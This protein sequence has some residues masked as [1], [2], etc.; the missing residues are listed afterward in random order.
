LDTSNN[1]FVTGNA[2]TIKYDTEGNQVW[3][4]P[5]AGTSIAV[6]GAGSAYVVGFGTN[7]NMEKLTANG[8]TIW[9]TS[10][11]YI[12]FPRDPPPYVEPGPLSSQLVLV[13]SQTNIYVAGIEQA[14]PSFNTTLVVIKYSANGNVLWSALSP[15]YYEG[16]F[17]LAG[18]T[19]DRSNN[20]YFVGNG[21][22]GEQGFQAFKYSNSGALEWA[23]VGLYIFL[24]S[25]GLIESVVV[26][27]SN[28][29]FVAGDVYSN[30]YFNGTVNINSSGDGNWTNLYPL[31]TALPP[32]FNP[33]LPPNFTP[34]NVGPFIAVDQ[35]NN[36]YVT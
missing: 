4:A 24:E 12:G 9:Q 36:V 20:I 23:Q 30:G 1:V 22:G 33:K 15:N 5:Y 11:G 18:A 31:P 27:N 14:L 19:L 28:N 32:N 34:E 26:D 8:S 35:A 29:V 10:S 7:F 6:D 21:G 3:S 25:P 2:G 16:F 17:A 13:D